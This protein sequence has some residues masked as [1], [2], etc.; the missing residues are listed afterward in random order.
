MA[1][2]KNC[3]AE[4]CNYGNDFLLLTEKEKREVLK[5]AK[6]L[7]KLQKKNDIIKGEKKGEKG[8]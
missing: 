7:L 2:H 6:N 1:K 8:D 5:N 3:I 4:P